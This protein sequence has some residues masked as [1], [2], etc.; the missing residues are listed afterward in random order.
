MRIGEVRP[1]PFFM[2]LIIRIK[3]NNFGNLDY[4]PY[5][6]IIKL[7][8]SLMNN[9]ILF[10]LRKNNS[11]GAEYSD[12]NIFTSKSGLL[13]SAKLTAEALKENL[14]LDAKIEVCFDANSIDREV[15]LFKPRYCILEAL[16]VTP[17]KMKEIAR[18]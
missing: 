1:S 9:K 12:P 4:Y 7:S 18:L 11:S 17:D 16:W 8:P 13:N 6:C 3:Q 2:F 10:L 15:H 5:I 14:G